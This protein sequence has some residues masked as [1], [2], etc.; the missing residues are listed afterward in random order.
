MADLPKNSEVMQISLENIL[1]SLAKNLYGDDWRVSIRELLQNAHDAITERVARAELKTPEIKVVLNTEAST[2]SFED[3][4]IGMKFTEVKEYLATVGYGRKREQIEALKRDN[5]GNREELQKIIGQYGIGFLSSFI[6]AENVEVL[7]KSALDENAPATRAV[8]TG[9][10]KWYHEATTRATAGTTV[11]VRLKKEAVT[12]PDDGKVKNLKELLSFTRLESEIR[13][14]GDLLPFPI[15]VCR[16][17]GDRTPT[18]AN[19]TIGAW[20]KDSCRKDDLE[21]FLKNRRKSEKRTCL[22]GAIFLRPNSRTSHHGTWN[23]IFPTPC[24]EHS[25]G[26]RVCLARGLVLP[27]DVYYRRHRCPA[28]RMGQICL[29]CGRMPQ[30]FPHVESQRCGSSRCGFCGSQAAVGARDH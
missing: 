23:T 30:S 27:A 15:M 10:T 3:N 24:A 17:P 12:D 26:F 11:I 16:Y 22:G 6:I 1:P 19:T 8:F 7:T 20:E 4:G 2:I 9:E 13:R 18:V 28:A 14:F 29:C 21:L 25:C 5:T